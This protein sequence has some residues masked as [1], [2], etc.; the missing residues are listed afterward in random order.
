MVKTQP[1]SPAELPEGSS[2]DDAQP[3]SCSAPAGLLGTLDISWSPH[4][5]PDVV[6]YNV[7]RSLT[8][9]GPF[10]KVNVDLVTNTT[11]RN[12]GLDSDK[13]YHYV[14]TA[15]DRFGNE[16]S[17]SVEVSATTS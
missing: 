9:G 4:P 16:S 7:Y 13:K 15:V 17:N 5:N 2:T 8:S 11:Y 12:S 1:L 14:I 6:G 3:V 10:E